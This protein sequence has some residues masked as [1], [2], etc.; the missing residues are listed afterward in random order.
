[1]TEHY[2]WQAITILIP[3]V[4]GGFITIRIHAYN[5]KQDKNARIS[6]MKDA[7][8]QEIKVHLDDMEKEDLTTTEKDH[9]FKTDLKYLE[10]ASFESSVN[11]GDFILLPNNLRKEISLHYISIHLSN[12]QVHQLIQSQFTVTD[13]TKKLISIINLQLET[14]KKLQKTIIKSS[15]EILEKL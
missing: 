14:L 13:N 3:I 11:S 4:L 1:M 9:M 6:N 7:I 15:K 2:F 10:T 8:K 5:Q 12:N